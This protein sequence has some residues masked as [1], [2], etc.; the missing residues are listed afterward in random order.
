MYYKYQYFLYV[1][2][3]LETLTLGMEERIQMIKGF[4]SHDHVKVYFQMHRITSF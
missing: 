3:K 1:F 2:D 4:T